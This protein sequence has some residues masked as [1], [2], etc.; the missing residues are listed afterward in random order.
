MQASRLVNVYYSDLVHIH[1][2]DHHNADDDESAQANV[3]L[4]IADG[5]THLNAAF[6]QT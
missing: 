5:V 2:W 1:A 6:L 4:F 3:H